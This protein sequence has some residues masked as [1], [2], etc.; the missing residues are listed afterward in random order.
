MAG[1]SDYCA[2]YGHHASVA[3][4]KAVAEFAGNPVAAISEK[5][6]CNQAS[7]RSSICPPYMT[8]PIIVPAKVDYF[9]L[10]GAAG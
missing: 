8:G 10:F 3:Q 2:I 7:I 9:E 1:Q 6:V 5:Q 4:V